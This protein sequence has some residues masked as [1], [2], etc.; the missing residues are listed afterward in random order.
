MTTPQLFIDPVVL[1]QI[2]RSL[3]LEFLQHFKADLKASNHILPSLDISDEDFFSSFAALLS[4][5]AALPTSMNEAL[6]AI[7]ELAAPENQSRLETTVFNALSVSIRGPLRYAL[8]STSGSSAHTKS[9]KKAAIRVRRRP[10]RNKVTAGQSCRPQPPV[11]KVTATH[12]SC[13]PSFA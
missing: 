4:A 3:L 12:G 10:R 7:A 11:P 1:Q 9:R 5:P 8:L 13:S 6:R 2:D